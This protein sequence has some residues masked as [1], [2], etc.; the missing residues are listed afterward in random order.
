MSQS[1]GSVTFVRT[2]EN[3]FPKINGKLKYVLWFDN[4]IT[5]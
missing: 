4:F 3:Y 1:S 5:N 2:Q